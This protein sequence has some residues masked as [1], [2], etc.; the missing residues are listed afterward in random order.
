MA[1]ISMVFLSS[2][3]WSSM[4]GVSTTCCHT[5]QQ[6][7]TELVK[8]NTS[9]KNNPEG[10]KLSLCVLKEQ[11]VHYPTTNIIKKAEFSP[12]MLF[13]KRSSIWRDVTYLP[14]EVSVVHV[15]HK[16]RLGGKSV[17]LDIHVCSR[18]LKE[19]S[20]ATSI[21]LLSSHLQ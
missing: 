14:A 4:P 16:Q 3:G 13:F 2:R 12:R 15:T 18:H 8:L 21:K 5:N 11:W 10:R 20:Y 19:N 6:N 9:N 1:C 17:W 7:T